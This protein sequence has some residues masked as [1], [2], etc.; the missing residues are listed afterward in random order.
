MQTDGDRIVREKALT[1]S[2]G[3]AAYWE[4]TLGDNLLGYYLLGS[5]AHGGFNRRYSDVDIG[6]ISQ[7]PLKDKDLEAEAKEA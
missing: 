5:L 3:L 6:L 4:R 2:R 7:V 1:L